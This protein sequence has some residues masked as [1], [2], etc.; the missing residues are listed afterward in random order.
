MISIQAKKHDNFS[1]EFK[2]GYNCIEDGVKDKF[3]VNAW[4]F[5]PNSL[6]INPENYGKKQFYRDIKSNIR[7]ITPVYLLRDIAQ[8]TS[9]PLVSLKKA[10]QNVVSNSSTSSLNAYEYH[11]KMF[12]A[13]F[14]SALRDHV[15]HLTSIRSLE[16][17]E[18]LVDDY[19]NSSQLVL[20]KFRSLY[21]IIDVPT[22]SDRTRSFFRMSDEFMSHVVVL[23]TTRMLTALEVSGCSQSQSHIRQK[24]IDLIQEERKYMAIMGYETLNGDPEHDRQLVFHHGMLKKYVESEL[25]IRLDKKKDGVAVEQLYY[26]IAAGVAMIFATGVAWQTQVKYGNITWPLFIA[27]VVSYMLKDR[28]KD[29]LRYYFAHKLGDKYFDKKA[30]IAIGDKK[31]GVIKEGFDFISRAKTPDV[32]MKMREKASFVEDESHIF[33]EKILLYRKHVEISDSALAQIDAYPMKGVNEIIRLHLNRFTHKMDNPEVPIHSFDAEGNMMTSSVQ[34][35]YYVN[36]VFQLQHEGEAEYHHFRLT[37]TR[38]GVQ[39][40]DEI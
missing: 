33:E 6:D 26:S 17:A 32:V 21:Q 22:V 7:L 36:V 11:L 28:I 10:L 1:V 12:A 18:Y 30:T 8:D 14:K 37:M 4:I 19:V 29:L 15:A 24:F 25:Y 23:R 34:K 38:N 5:V 13:I 40:I 20:N 9:L 39:A 2:F 31:V 3:S 35:I 27:L 16:S